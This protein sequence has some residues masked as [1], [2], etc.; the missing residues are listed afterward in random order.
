MKLKSDKPGAIDG[1][2]ELELVDGKLYGNIFQTN[3]ILRIDPASGCVEGRADMGSL[4]RAMTDADK[5]QVTADSNNVL[6]GI[7][8]DKDVG[9]VL[10][11]RQ[12]LAHHLRRPVFPP[13]IGLRRTRPHWRAPRRGF[14]VSSG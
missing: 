14:T 13:E 2:N 3:L 1:L 9:P 6:N 11:H 5:K 4:W 10:R 12:A 8:Y 7:A